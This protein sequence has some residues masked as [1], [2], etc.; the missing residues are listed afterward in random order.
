MERFCR[1]GVTFHIYKDSKARHWYKL[2]LGRQYLHIIC[3]DTELDQSTKGIATRR[4]G[5]FNFKLILHVRG[6]EAV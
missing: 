5:G 3:F 2:T 6:Q 4:T 1:E